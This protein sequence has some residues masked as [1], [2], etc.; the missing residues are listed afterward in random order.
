MN[1]AHENVWKWYIIRTENTLPQ[2]WTFLVNS[3]TVYALFV[4]PFVLVF[5]KLQKQL[6]G[7]ELFIDICFTMDI[8]LNFFKLK[9]NQKEIEFNEYRMEYVKGL[10]VFDIIAV[11]PGLLTGDST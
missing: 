5:P 6:Q 4:T 10:L 3:L 11:M 9:P 7:F 1:Q 8:V 2:L